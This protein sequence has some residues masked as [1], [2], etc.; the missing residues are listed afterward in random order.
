MSSCRATLS[1]VWRH[2]TLGARYSYVPRAFRNVNYSDSSLGGYLRRTWASFSCQTLETCPALA[3]DS[4]RSVRIGDG[5]IERAPVA[6][7]NMAIIEQSGDGIAG[8]CAAIA[9]GPVTK[10]LVGGRLPT[11]HR[12]S[13]CQFDQAISS[14]L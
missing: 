8:F 14:A 4:P 11:A 5:E 10:L 9:S 6:L 1:E 7:R 2:L 12:C 3:I 13:C